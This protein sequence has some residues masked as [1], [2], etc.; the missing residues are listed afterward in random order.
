MLVFYT[1]SAK[2]AKCAKSPSRNV[3][4]FYIFLYK[5]IRSHKKPMRFSIASRSCFYRCHWTPLVFLS[6]WLCRS[7]YIYASVRLEVWTCVR[8][9]KERENFSILRELCKFFSH[10]FYWFQ[11]YIWKSYWRNI[12]GKRLQKFWKVSWWHYRLKSDIIHIIIV[13]IYQKQTLKYEVY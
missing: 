8:T 11:V 5:F 2:V 6:K 12:I 4:W 1:R 3:Y 7:S 13:V 10:F 9:K